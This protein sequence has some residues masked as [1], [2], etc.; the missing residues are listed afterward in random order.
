MKYTFA[1]Y[2]VVWDEIGDPGDDDRR[3]RVSCGSLSIPRDLPLCFGHG[4]SRHYARTTDGSLS[5]WMDDFGCAVEFQI[6]D[7]GLANTINRGGTS[8]LSFN[9]LISASRIEETDAGRVE[10]V[11][12]A[13]VDELSVVTQPKMTNAHCWLRDWDQLEDLPPER[14]RL[15]LNWENGLLSRRSFT[16]PARGRGSS[17]AA[18]SPRDAGGV[19]VL[20]LGDLSSLRRHMRSIQE[21]DSELQLFQ[22]AA[23]RH[24]AKLQRIGTRAES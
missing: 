18:A 3:L 14:R 16:P 7:F 21:Q 2:A 8:G 11:Q 15:V 17:P 10:I 24:A 13:D 9:Y 19:G 12:Q 23:A 6:E 20:S 1:G 5:L 4:Q 22:A